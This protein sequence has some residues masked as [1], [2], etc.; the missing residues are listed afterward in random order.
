[1][2]RFLAIAQDWNQAGLSAL[3]Q[4]LLARWESEE[5]L[6]EAMPLSNAVSLQTIHSS[7]GLA[8]D[9]VIPI[10]TATRL[11]T[12]ADCVTDHNDRT[13]TFRLF[14]KTTRLHEERLKREQLERM[15]EGLRLWYVALTRARKQLLL[16]KLDI[17]ED[18]D[19]FSLIELPLENLETWNR[20]IKATRGSTCRI[21]RFHES[22]R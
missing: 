5:R 17:R 4:D 3:T 10:N 19:W 15:R 20:Q 2:E 1:M 18:G 9:V 22:A 8:W 7:K 21:S 14:G 6:E 13:L 12:R 11:D 16:P